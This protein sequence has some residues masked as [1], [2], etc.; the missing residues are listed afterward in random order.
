MRIR[1]SLNSCEVIEFEQDGVEQEF[2]API[3]AGVN[4]GFDFVAEHEWGVD[5]AAKHLGRA[6]KLDRFNY[7][8]KARTNTKCEL[9]L[10]LEER[11]N[12]EVWLYGRP[13]DPWREDTKTL[14]QMLDDPTKADPAL[15]DEVGFVSIVGAEIRAAWGGSGGFAVVGQSDKGKA[16]VRLVYDALKNNACLIDQRLEFLGRGGLCL[17]DT[18]VL[19]KSF[20]E[21]QEQAD[22]NWLELQEAAEATGIVKTLADAGKKYY[23]LEPA[24]K[25][26]EKTAV[27]FYLNPHDQANCRYG[28]FN[29]RQLEEWAR[30]EGAVLKAN[31]RDDGGDVRQ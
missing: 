29:V 31:Q 17:I 30:D 12:G 2:S 18:R 4:L 6:P 19:P 20:W 26:K 27:H 25:D 23:A 5:W 7:G 28:W 16:A 14:R 24:W 13:H 3:L 1:R 11:D 8:V 15:R 21:R 22:L 9:T 10:E